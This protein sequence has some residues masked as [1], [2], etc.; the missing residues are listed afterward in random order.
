MYKHISFCIPK[1]AFVTV[2]IAF[3]FFFFTGN[4]SSDFT[5]RASLWTGLMYNLVEHKLSKK[6][7]Q[8]FFI[9][10]FFFGGERTVVVLSR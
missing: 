9:L 6:W 1:S 8:F 3:C 7:T 4:S 2:F 10:F 5:Y